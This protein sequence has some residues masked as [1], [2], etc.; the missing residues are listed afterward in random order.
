MGDG[1]QSSLTC[2]PEMRKFEFGAALVDTG[3]MSADSI[4]VYLLRHM[5]GDP[6]NCED[7]MRYS[8]GSTPRRPTRWHASRLLAWSRGF[9]TTQMGFRSPPRH[10]TRMSGWTVSSPT[11]IGYRNHSMY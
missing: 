5:P 10:S 11:S 1:V 4:T 8:S 6:E 9:A 7:E 2:D 3:T